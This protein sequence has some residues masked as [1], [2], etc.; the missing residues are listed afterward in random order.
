M[1]IFPHTVAG[2]V[3]GSFFENPLL[4]ALAGG[5]SH[6]VLDF[7]P[8]FDPDVSRSHSMPRLKKTIVS[9]VIAVDILIGLAAL[10]I[11]KGH[12]NLIAGGLAGPMVDLDNFLQ[13]KFKAFPLLS[14]IGLTVHDEGSSW[15]KKL[16]TG[17]FLL[18]FLIG[19]SLQLAIFFGGLVYLASKYPDICPSFLR[20]FCPYQ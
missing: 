13:Y 10:W 9:C 4:A 11:L 15:H 3:A 1:S 7:I 2:A 16:H 6:F 18:D 14:K 17:S 12:F 5:A 20:L 19:V 8:H